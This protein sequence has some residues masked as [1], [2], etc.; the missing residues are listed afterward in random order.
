MKARRET[1]SILELCHKFK[2]KNE[3]LMLNLNNGSEG[4]PCYRKVTRTCIKV[5][6]EEERTSVV[7]SGKNLSW[8][9]RQ[10]RPTK[11]YESGASQ[12]MKEG[13]F[14][15][16]EKRN[17]PRFSSVKT[18]DRSEFYDSDGT[19][20]DSSSDEEYTTQAG[21]FQAQN[22]FMK[23]S[24]VPAARLYRPGYDVM[25]Q[26]KRDERRMYG[27]QVPQEQKNNRYSQR[28]VGKHCQGYCQNQAN[29]RG[30]QAP[31]KADGQSCPR[32]P[33]NHADSLEY[34]HKQAS[35]PGYSQ[36]QH[37]NRKEK[38]VSYQN[39]TETYV[40]LQ[41]NEASS[42][43]GSRNE[44]AKRETKL[45]PIQQ[46]N[47]GA[48]NPE[49][50]PALPRQLIRSRERSENHQNCKA[51]PTGRRTG[52]QEIH[53]AKKYMYG[54]N[55]S[56]CPEYK[57][58]I[59][60]LPDLIYP[61]SWRQDMTIKVSRLADNLWNGIQCLTECIWSCVTWI[62]EVMRNGVTWMGRSICNGVTWMGKSICNGVTWMGRS[63][64]NCV[65]WVGQL[66]R[67]GVTWMSVSMWNCVTWMA[68]TMWIGILWTGELFIP[69][70][71][72]VAD[73]VV[74]FYDEYLDG[75][76]AKTE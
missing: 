53:K 25:S 69:A 73:A 35:T 58:F 49:A 9:S 22:G 5:H 17:E 51:L 13:R 8:H 11:A 57:P 1:P 50:L 18:P 24:N 65:I 74:K 10:S 27:T 28:V 60:R 41:R 7:Q 40:Y 3:E 33:H 45:P 16:V 21:P 76:L 68:E 34:S 26:P 44:C 23:T 61:L 30:Y 48:R 31:N 42:R 4:S 64:W 72:Y 59:P 19:D 62:G 36:Y 12:G 54:R 32:Y 75:K 37:Q 39:T 29:T 66:I 56:T 55:D 46:C 52:R 2:N 63:I 20:T 70:F 38:R 47:N 6:E 71:N 14:R 67:I 15:Y 43:Q